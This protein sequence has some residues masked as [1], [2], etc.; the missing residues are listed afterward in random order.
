MAG[1]LKSRLI[2][3]GKTRSD[4]ARASA[5]GC[6]QKLGKSDMTKSPSLSAQY[7]LRGTSIL[8]WVRIPFN[9]MSLANLISFFM[10]SSVGKV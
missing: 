3:C 4:S 1:W 6:P 10:N 8:M 9:P 7:S 2:N 5:L